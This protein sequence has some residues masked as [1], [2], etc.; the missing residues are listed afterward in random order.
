MLEDKCWQSRM[1][2]WNLQV[3]C[4]DLLNQQKDVRTKTIADDVLWELE[5]RDDVKTRKV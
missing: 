2:K 3:G 1:A 4:S 5:G